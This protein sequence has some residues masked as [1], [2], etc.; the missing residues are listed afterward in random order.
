MLLGKLVAA[1]FR[2]LASSSIAYLTKLHIASEIHH[3]GHGR[4]VKNYN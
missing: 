1:C 3:L 2:K 4:I